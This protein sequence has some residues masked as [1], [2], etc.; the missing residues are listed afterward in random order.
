MSWFND[1]GDGFR[2]HARGRTSRLVA[3][4]YLDAAELGQL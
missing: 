2:H 1:F 4:F 3:E